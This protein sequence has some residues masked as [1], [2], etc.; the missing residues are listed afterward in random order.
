MS[1]RSRVCVA[2]CG[3]WGKNLVR[4]FHAL[5]HLTAVCETKTE[6]RESIVAQY[7]GIK[8]FSNLSDACNDPSIDAIVL[9]TPAES[10][11]PMGMQVLRSDKDLFVEKPLALESQDGDELVHEARTRGRILM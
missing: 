2:G 1:G 8:S 5:G 6:T 11:H 10:H 4:N 7:P 3:H 9:A